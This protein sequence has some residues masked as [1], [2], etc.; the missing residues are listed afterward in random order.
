MVLPG[1]SSRPPLLAVPP[2]AAA[3]LLGGSGRA[4]IVWSQLRDGRDPFEESSGLGHKARHALELAFSAQPPHSLLTS[5][6]SAC[7]TRK[8]LLRLRRGDEVEAR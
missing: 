8:L 2:T 1:Q 5:T 4:K 7:G 6:V 3:D